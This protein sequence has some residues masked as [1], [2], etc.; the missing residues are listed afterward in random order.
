MQRIRK[1][2]RGAK[3]AMAMRIVPA[4]H[5]LL[6]RSFRFFRPMMGLINRA[7]TYVMADSYLG[8]VR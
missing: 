3:L 6:A 5:S 2:V 8:G 1:Q 7:N 4:V